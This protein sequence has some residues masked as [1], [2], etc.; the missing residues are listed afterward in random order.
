MQWGDLGWPT[1]FSAFRLQ[2]WV[3]S[4]VGHFVIP[5]EASPEDPPPPGLCL[6]R[7]HESCAVGA[8]FPLCVLPMP[9]APE[10]RIRAEAGPGP[11]V[12]IVRRV[13]STLLSRSVSSAHAH[14]HHN[15]RFDPVL[16]YLPCPTVPTRAA[17]RISED[18][19]PSHSFSLGSRRT[20]VKAEG[21]YFGHVLK[22]TLSHTLLQSHLHPALCSY[23]I[24]SPS[25][26]LA[27]LIKYP[28]KR[29]RGRRMVVVRGRGGLFWFPR[30]L[31]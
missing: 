3:P 7:F 6:P 9:P 13:P 28:R 2:E 19:G 8:P 24:A 22:C 25:L 12:Q 30:L 21:G 14:S 29:G 1:S 17:G 5:W 18:T 20:L 31:V 27:A 23:P 11:P 16:I 26:F 4:P 15:P 10:H